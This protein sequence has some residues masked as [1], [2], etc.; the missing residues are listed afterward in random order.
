MNHVFLSA[1]HLGMLVVSGLGLAGLALATDRHGAHL[2]GHQPTP[3]QRRCAQVVGW[4][5]LATALA[6]SVATLGAGIG[7]TLWLGWLGLAAW[8]LIFALPQWPWQPVEPQRTAR[9]AAEKNI[10]AA[11][12]PLR[13]TRVRRWCAGFALCATLVAFTA[14]LWQ[15]QIHAQ[16]Q[17][18]VLQGKVGPWSFTLEEADQ[19]PPELVAMDIP[20][21]TFHLRFCEACDP[22]I[23]QVTLK[24][25]RPRNT[26]S[27][28]MAFMGQRWERKVEIPLP[29]TLREESELWLTV[30]GKDASVYQSAW[31]M[32]HVSPATVQWFEQ[33]RKSHAIP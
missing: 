27:T 26:G 17:R 12:V 9:R 18:R 3:G 14:L 24:V 19:K 6:W 28:G 20:M 32:D 15:E 29:D 2:L 22:E 21:K 4:L 23:R 25:N 8:C 1:V 7:V 30:V 11:P 16:S 13:D 5:L 10:P 33:Q 31:R